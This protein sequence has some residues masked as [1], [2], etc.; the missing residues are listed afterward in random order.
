METGL[1]VA[2]RWRV[3]L[4]LGQATDMEEDDPDLLSPH[5]KDSTSLAME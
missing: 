3:L 5:I 4:S 1:D 2:R